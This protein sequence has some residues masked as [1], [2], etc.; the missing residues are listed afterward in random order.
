MRIA[1]VF[2]AG[3][4]VPACGLLEPGP[5]ETFVMTRANHLPLPTPV[6]RL[7]NM[8][9]SI[10]EVQ[11]IGGSIRLYGHGRMAREFSTRNMVSGTPVDT[12]IS[13]RW[14]GSYQRTDSTLTIRFRFKTSD[15]IETYVYRLGDGGRT[16]RGTESF[17]GLFPAVYEYVRR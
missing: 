1:C 9:G 2:F 8:N 16:L 17:E 10:Y 7:R 5:T 3:I 15:Y 11:A 12:L 6:I 4:L 13:V 14:T